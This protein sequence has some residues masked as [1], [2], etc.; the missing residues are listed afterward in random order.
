MMMTTKVVKQ[1]TTQ[2]TQQSERRLRV[3]VDFFLPM[4]EAEQQVA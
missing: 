4:S 1:M 2:T 3:C